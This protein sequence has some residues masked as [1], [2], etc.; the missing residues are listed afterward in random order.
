MSAAKTP[1]APGPDATRDP[2]VDA[3]I[4]RVPEF[5]QPLLRRLR[6]G[7]HAAH[8]GITEANKWG[9]PHFMYS[10]RILASMAAFKAHATFGFWQGEEVARTGKSDE[11]M[12][13]FG[14]LTSPKDL[15][16]AT[17]LKT[18]VRRAVALI[19]AGAPPRSNR[20]SAE[21]KPPAMPPEFFR[22]ALSR[23]PAAR[24]TFEGF[25]P[26]QQREYI[27]WLAEAKQE[28]TRERRL[29]QAIEWL[30]T[31]KRRNWKYENC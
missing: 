22:E 1:P 31:G 11:A 9:M 7:V 30:A 28:A 10:G 16:T 15:P 18:M 3:Y 13:Q 19:D 23:H 21:P 29:T 26:S 2:R 14:R 5:A 27:E 4:D 6:D 8:P 12:G 25:P 17:Q 24:A 20:R